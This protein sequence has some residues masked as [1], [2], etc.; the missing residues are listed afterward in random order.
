MTFTPIQI[1]L[2][3]CAKYWYTPQ[4]SRI[5]NTRITM[6]ITDISAITTTKIWVA[7]DSYA[8]KLAPK[9]LNHP[10]NR[11]V[12]STLYSSLRPY[13]FC[14]KSPGGA[15][16]LV[17]LAREL[18]MTSWHPRASS[19]SLS[20]CYLQAFRAWQYFPVKECLRASSSSNYFFLNL[21]II[22]FCDRDGK[23]S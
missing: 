6:G 19:S 20:P 8:T 18:C 23:P 16:P 17:S 3:I 1:Q 10:Q 13:G 22:I 15:P 11:C 2:Q 21:T 14:A 7:L 4:L 9:L 5:T 12:L